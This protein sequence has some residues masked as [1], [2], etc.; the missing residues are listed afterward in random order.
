M[1]SKRPKSIRVLGK[2]FAVVLEP[3][4]VLERSNVGLCDSHAQ[5]IT[6]LEGLYPEDERET[7]LH[8]VV[9][10]VDEAVFTDLTEHQVGALSR[11]LLAVF[12][13]NPAFAAWLLEPCGG[14]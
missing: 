2:S 9:H 13:D 5:T 12:A 1:N 4:G 8:E 7:L 10:A 14:A 6:V 3:A 11:G